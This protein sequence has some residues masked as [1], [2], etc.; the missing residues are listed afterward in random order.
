MTDDPLKTK[1]EIARLK[2]GEDV[3]YLATFGS[4]WTYVETLTE[5]LMRG[6][7]PSESIMISE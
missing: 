4:E 1:G 5:P 2:D 3:R 6:F 7:V